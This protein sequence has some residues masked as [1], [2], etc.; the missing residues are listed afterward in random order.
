MYGFAGSG[1]GNSDAPCPVPGLCPTP[2]PGPNPANPY[3]TLL[4]PA[5]P[6]SSESEGD[7]STEK[8]DMDSADGSS[9]ESDQSSEG[10]MDTDAMMLDVDTEGTTFATS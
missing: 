6:Q 8:S 10:G 5:E 3:P 2:G 1:P 4:P 7:A 9:W